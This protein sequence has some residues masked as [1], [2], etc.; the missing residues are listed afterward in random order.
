MNFLVEIST[1]LANGTKS[2][3]DELASEPNCNK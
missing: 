1:I 3:M 2:L